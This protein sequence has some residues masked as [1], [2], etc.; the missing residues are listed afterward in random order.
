MG[1]YK[2]PHSL[3]FFS[4]LYT[5]MKIYVQTITDLEL[6]LW[7][8]DSCLFLCL[9]ALAFICFDFQHPFCFCQ[10][11]P[12]PG[13]SSLHFLACDP[14]SHKTILYFPLWVNRIVCLADTT[15]WVPF[16][17]D[18]YLNLILN[19]KN[20]F[21]CLNTIV[22][23]TIFLSFIENVFG[24]IM[25]NWCSGGIWQFHILPM[26]I[27]LALWVKYPYCIS[28]RTQPPIP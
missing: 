25:W 27:S 21:F 28:L 11:S 17:L 1:I 26:S 15:F 24:W 19:L 7:T 13:S 3:K 22:V 4:F 8:E 2:C 12:F 18:L 16:P 9:T 23:I 6:H 14:I 10:F 20:N 5:Y